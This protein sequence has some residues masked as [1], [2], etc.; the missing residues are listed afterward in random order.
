MFTKVKIFSDSSDYAY[1]VNDT[2][3]RYHPIEV[4]SVVVHDEM[5]VVTYKGK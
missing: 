5:L 3:Q 4:I 1:W 2:D